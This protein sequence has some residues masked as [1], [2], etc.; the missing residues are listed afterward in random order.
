MKTDYFDK[1]AQ[2]FAN[3]MIEKIQQVEDNWQKPWITIAANTRNFFPQNLTGRRYAGGNAF[4]LLFLCEKFQYQTPVFMT[5]NQAKE[6][7]I[8]VLKGS[9]SF[10]VYYF[11]FYVYHKETRKKITFEEYKALSREQ[12]QEYNVI[13]TYKYY[14]VFNLDQTNFSDVRPEE[15]EALREKFRG[16]QAEQPDGTTGEAH[17]EIDA[18]LE[19]KSWFCPIREQQGDRAFYSPLADYIV[20]PLRSQFVDMQSFYETLLHEMGHSTGHLDQTN[21]SDVRPEE[22]EALRE[23]FR[24][25]QAEQ[26]DGTTGEAHPEIDAMLE[27]KSWFCPIREQQGD[28]AFYSPLADYIVVPLRSQFVD[29][30]SFYETLLHEMGHSTGHPTRLNR[31]LAHPFGSEEYGKEELTA[32]FAAALAGMFFGIA[33]HIRTENAAYLKSWI[34]AIREE[35]KFILNVLADAMKIVK[36]I[37]GKL[38]ISVE[39]EETAADEAE[40]VA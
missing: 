18:M 14:S 40:Q 15:W 5:F 13:P 39:S 35:P 8:S 32:E 11:L 33:E 38:N 36:M 31:D 22:W 4:L 20:V 23:K 26:P 17:P 2:Q 28:R 7:G 24:G 16:G 30:Q 27:A 19:A 34:K 21:F 3:L 12:Q 29:M 6:A 37:A 10:P 9:K 25:G 1:A